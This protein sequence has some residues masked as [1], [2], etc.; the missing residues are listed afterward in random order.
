MEKGLC[1]GAMGVAAVMALIFVLD[2]AAGFPFGGSP[3]FLGDLLGLL[4]S[5]IVLYL[6][7]NASRDL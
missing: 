6:G 1:Y 4:A 5:L 2:M 3:F 7:F